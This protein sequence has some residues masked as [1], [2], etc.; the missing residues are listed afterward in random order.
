M[1]P[2][3]RAHGEVPLDAGEELAPVWP[4]VQRHTGVVALERRRAQRV[5]LSVVGRWRGQVPGKQAVDFVVHDICATGAKVVVHGEHRLWPLGSQRTLRLQV[6]DVEGSVALVAQ[7]R[8]VEL[9]RTAMG[10]SVTYGLLVSPATQRA[11]AQWLRALLHHGQSG[12]VT[13]TPKRLAKEGLVVREAARAL[14]Y[15]TLQSGTQLRQVMQ[16][17]Y[18][19]YQ[20]L[21][22]LP[23]G[24]SD[25][26]S[27]TDAWDATGQ[28][29]VAWMGDLAV[30][31]ARTSAPQAGDALTLDEWLPT[32]KGLPPLDQVVECSR[33]AVHRDFR[34]YDLL[35]T[36]CQYLARYALARK[37]RYL[38]LGTNDVLAHY[39]TRFGARP[40]GITGRYCNAS[41]H[42]MVIDLV[43]V[44]REGDAQAREAMFGTPPPLDGASVRMPKW[45]S[46]LLAR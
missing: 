4:R 32:R 39:Y 45:R 2:Q 44:W 11:Q 8:R 15:T 35:P 43:R 19:C 46:Y 37:R 41:A 6:P 3:H 42:V 7:V 16:L 36:M 18:E 29:V 1:A 9:A 23:D 31:T 22:L 20:E 12:G 26:A 34:G 30:A 38:L 13:L 14:R 25:V 10:N 28:V 27:M 5:R 33:L 17:R 24:C 40:I 21:G